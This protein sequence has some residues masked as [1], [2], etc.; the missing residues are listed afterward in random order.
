MLSEIN[1]LVRQTQANTKLSHL[2]VKF[3]KTKTTPQ[4]KKKKAELT[5][6]EN[7]LVV[8]RGRYMMWVTSV[9][10]KR[11]RLPRYKICCECTMYKDGNY[12]HNTALNI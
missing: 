11:Y 9:K 2:Y 6:T 3:K 1:Q 4:K 8:T 7:R 5:D 12:V 10:V